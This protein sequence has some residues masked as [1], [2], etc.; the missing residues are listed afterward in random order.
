MFYFCQL[1]PSGLHINKENPRK[2]AW[3][4]KA[5]ILQPLENY[6]SCFDV[7]SLVGF[8]FFFSFWCGNSLQQ[9]G[10]EEQN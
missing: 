4:R 10:L 9:E 2:T 5:A 7:L 6:F 3:D 8:G 1:A